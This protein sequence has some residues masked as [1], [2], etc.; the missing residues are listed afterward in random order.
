[1]KVP[2]CKFH[3]S[4]TITPHLN[5]NLNPFLFLIFSALRELFSDFESSMS[6]SMSMSMQKYSPIPQLADEKSTLPDII[7]GDVP[8]HVPA[9][10]QDDVEEEI[11]TSSVGEIDIPSSD[12]GG[13]VVSSDSSK[14]LESKENATPTAS[15]ANA[16]GSNINEK[17]KTAMIG[18][19]SVAAVAV[20]AAA[21]ARKLHKKA[22]AVKATENEMSTTGDESDSSPIL[23]DVEI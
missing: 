23:Q 2:S 8:S 20:V 19:L 21:V 4:S 15:N 13:F 17:Q 9:E 16:K 3:P 18:V 22:M 1:M 12:Q 5:T 14:E 10:Q 7:S 11:A 6:M